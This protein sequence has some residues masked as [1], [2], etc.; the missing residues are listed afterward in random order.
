MGRHDRYGMESA[1]QMKCSPSSP[2]YKAILSNAR[3]YRQQVNHITAY[4]DA[5]TIHGS[6]RHWA[7]ALRTLDGTGPLKTSAGARLIQVS[8]RIRPFRLRRAV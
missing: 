1:L 7:M 4:I 6:D 8:V 2:A 5:S 3:S